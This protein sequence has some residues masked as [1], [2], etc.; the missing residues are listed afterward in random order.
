MKE[1]EIA[2]KHANSILCDVMISQQNQR[3]STSYDLKDQELLETLTH[4]H[5]TC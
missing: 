2:T 1:A 5:E 3:N 4:I